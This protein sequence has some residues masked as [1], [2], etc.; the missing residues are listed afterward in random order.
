MKSVWNFTFGKIWD[1]KRE[2]M[3]NTDTDTPNT[4]T[5]L[6]QDSTR[7][8]SPGVDQNEPV[9]E[10]MDVEENTEEMDAQAKALMHLLST[11]EVY[12]HL[13]WIRSEGIF[14]C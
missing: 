4:P 13:S 7:P 2:N 3:S 11:S 8:S 1:Q 6:R 12:A 10:K 14:S 9:P 5:D